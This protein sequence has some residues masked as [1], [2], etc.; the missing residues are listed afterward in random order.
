MKWTKLQKVGLFLD[1]TSSGGTLL[2]LDQPSLQILNPTYPHRLYPFWLQ[3]IRI[4]FRS[5]LSTCQDKRDP[6]SLGSRFLGKLTWNNYRDERIHLGCPPVT[7]CVNACGLSFPPVLDD[8]KGGSTAQTAASSQTHSAQSLDGT[9]D[10]NCEHCVNSWH[11][12]ETLA[13]KKCG[14]SV[15]FQTQP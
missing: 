7:L 5:E 13:N 14:V 9:C 8:D 12:H 11:C 10:E 3:A 4:W 6:C 2:I 1:S 15:L